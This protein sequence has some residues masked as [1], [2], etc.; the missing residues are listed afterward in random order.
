MRFLSIF[1]FFLAGAGASEAAA[2]AAPAA[3]SVV[4]Y[5]VGS[6]DLALGSSYVG[7]V[8]AIQSVSMLPQV[9]GTIDRVAFK[10]GSMVKAGDLLFKIDDEQYRAT[11]DGRKADLAKAEAAQKNAVR[12]Y[13]RLKA[14]DRRSV[15]ATDVDSA[16][17]DVL[18][19]KAG[20]AQAQAALKLAQIDLDH[21]RIPAPITGRIGKAAMTKG[22]Y[23]TP[24]GV[25]L[26]EIVQMD[27]IRVA[28]AMPDR[29]Y[30][31]HT[32]AS[33][34]L[35]YT[36]SLT[37]ADGTAYPF[38]GERDFDD[39]VVDSKTGTVTVRLRFPNSDGLLVPGAMVR[40]EVKP[41][42]HVGLVIPQEAVVSNSDGD[43]V[44]VVDSADVATPKGVKLGLAV[45]SMVEV[46]S[47]LAEGD[48]IVHQGIQSVIPGSPVSPVTIKKAAKTPA[49]LAMES[50][51]DLSTSS[52]ASPDSSGG[53]GSST[54]AN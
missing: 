1:L 24:A 11:V 10:E 19:A 8:E 25:P 26:A 29:D 22:N 30:S 34:D 41:A 18:Q 45:G 5:S 15:S 38:N 35:P 40:V 52:P 54:N 43:M 37:L 42:P 48:N 33:G 21:T 16:E 23:V 2:P 4:L 51:Y 46:L 44:Y 6:A 47:G 27:P 31:S 12:Y 7:R 20:V 36:S 49:E 28:F 3:P 9:T 50:G 17:N 53:G 13:D 14:A 32:P 39:N